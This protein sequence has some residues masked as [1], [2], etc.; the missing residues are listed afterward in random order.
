MLFIL[1]NILLI[2]AIPAWSDNNDRILF[3]HTRLI[4]SLCVQPV[5]IV[6][7]MPLHSE[8]IEFIGVL[9]FLEMEM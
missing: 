8:M 9:E 6:L 4:F 3:I 2:W 7:P 5:A 1:Q